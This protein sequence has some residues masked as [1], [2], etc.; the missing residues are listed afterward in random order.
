MIAVSWLDVLPLPLEARR[1]TFGGIE[2]GQ[3]I[4]L[5]AV[6]AR[7]DFTMG[8]QCPAWLVP[9]GVPVDLP[10]QHWVL[11]LFLFLF[12][13]VLQAEAGAAGCLSAGFP[14]ISVL[15]QAFPCEEV[16]PAHAVRMSMNHWVA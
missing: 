14:S 4:A 9:Q 11:P 12:G 8:A 10:R 7:Y 16:T 15:A 5:G 2:A 1:P 6:E 3:C 13:V